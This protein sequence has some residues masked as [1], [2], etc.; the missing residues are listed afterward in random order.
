MFQILKGISAKTLI[1]GEA[2]KRVSKVICLKTQ[3]TTTQTT[4]TTHSK[5]VMLTSK[6]KLR[7]RQSPRSWTPMSNPS[8]NQE[9]K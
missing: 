7:F 8:L 4:T 1:P 5:T 3:I 6:I 9:Q 2:A